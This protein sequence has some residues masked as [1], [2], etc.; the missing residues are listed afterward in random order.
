[1][2]NLFPIFLNLNGKNCLI[3]GGGQVAKRK[4]EDLLECGADIRIVSPEIDDQIKAWAHK[5][6]ITWLNR[7]FEPGDL[8]DIFMAFV[9]TDNSRINR[10]VVELCRKQ[11]ILVNAVDDPPNCDFYVPAV[12]RR[13][14]LILAISTEGKSPLFA[15]KL[16]RELEEII[17]SEY[18]EFVDILGEQREYLKENVPDANTRRKIFNALVYS[19]VLDLLRAGEKEKA[20]ERIKQCMCSWLD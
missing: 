16:R 15:R 20:R 2:A 4:A 12:I 13:N 9:A 3:I 10:E 19:D 17:T 7:E 5:G 14:S 8:Q 6:I 11:G 18:G 1:M